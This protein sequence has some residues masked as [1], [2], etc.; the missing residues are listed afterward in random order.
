MDKLRAQFR[1]RLQYVSTDFVRSDLYKIGWNAR[2]VG[3][4]G[5]RGIGKTTLLLQHIKLNYSNNLEEVLYISMD[6]LLVS[7]TS[8]IE[9]AEQFVQRGGKVLYIDELHKYH[10]W[11]QEL[12]NIY[13]DYPELKVVFT[14]SSLLEILHSK[15]D[16]SRRAILY[17]MQGMS[18]REFI[19]FEKQISLPSYSLEDIIAH[20]TEIA[21]ELTQRFKPLSLFKD[22][23]EYGYYPFYK[24]G[25]E[26]YDLKLN[27]VIQLILEIELPQHREVDIAYITKLKQLLLVIAEAVPF[28]PNISTLSQKMGIHRNTLMSY[29]HYLEEVAL[30]MNIYSASKGTSALQKPN[31]IYLENTNLVHALSQGNIS[32][33]TVRESFFANQ[34]RVSHQLHLPPK[35]D[36]IVDNTYVFEVGG[37]AKGIKQIKDV[38]NAYVVAD[39]IEIGFDRKIPLWLF[40]FLH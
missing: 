24:E 2:L 38:D 11:I 35:G 31:K 36:F 19:E 40:G 7:N 8:L 20:H 1:K 26:F 37:S 34:L 28:I 13:D 33:G 15:A 3:I 39:N 12:K 22:Y 16:L 10:S 27:Q 21:D 6:S 29:I 14:G 30:T 18:F 4:K 5:A 9:I 32:A 17:T 23:L 25:R